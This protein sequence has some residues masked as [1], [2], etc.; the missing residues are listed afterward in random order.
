MQPDAISSSRASTPK[1]VLLP[2]YLVCDVS[3]SMEPHIGAVNAILPSLRAAL[4]DNPILCDR[5]RFGV[6]DFAGDAREVLPLCDLTMLRDLPLMSPRE[7]GTSYTAAFSAL[8]GTLERDVRQLRSDGFAVN[9]PAVFFLTDGAP[10]D[11][12][13]DL[14]REAHSSLT[15][16]AYRPNIIPFG[17]GSASRTVLAE[18]ACPREGRN[19]M[20]V[21]L[22]AEGSDVGQA[23]TKTAEILIASVISSAGT[24]NL[25]LPPADDLPQGIDAFN[26]QDLLPD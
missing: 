11:K 4:L 22:A 23:I 21:F 6:L 10:T 3:T 24:G 7:G 13:L 2:F 18:V 19:A 14:F 20:S 25:T 8:G 26:P 15:D 9:R 17:V 12:P 16:S 5:V 1:A